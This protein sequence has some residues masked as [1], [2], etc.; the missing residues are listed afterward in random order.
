MPGVIVRY[1]SPLNAAPGQA[2]GVVSGAIGCYG[3]EMGKTGLDRSNDYFLPRH[4]RDELHSMETSEPD[5][6]LPLRHSVIVPSGFERGR[7]YVEGYLLREALKER[8]EPESPD[9]PEKKRQWLAAIVD[10]FVDVRAKAGG[11]RVAEER[12]VTER[13]QV[14]AL[15][16]TVSP[17]PRDVARLSTRGQSMIT[18]LQETIPQMWRAYEEEQKLEPGSVG[19]VWTLHLDKE[20][21]HAHCFLLPHAANGQRL[22]LS[23][24]LVSA[25]EPDGPRLRVLSDLRKHTLAIYERELEQMEKR[26]PVVSLAQEIREGIAARSLLA[27]SSKVATDPKVLR[28]AVVEKAQQF[29]PAGM[30]PSDL[31]QVLEGW[32]RRGVAHQ[33]A[34]AKAAPFQNEQDTKA[35]ESKWWRWMWLGLRVQKK[36]AQRVVSESVVRHVADGLWRGT[37]QATPLA[38]LRPTIEKTIRE[39]KPDV[40]GAL[41]GVA[42]DAPLRRLLKEV[43]RAIEDGRRIFIRSI[44]HDVMAA[45]AVVAEGLRLNFRSEELGVA[46]ITS[47]RVPDA[48]RPA[49]PAAPDN[50]PDRSSE[51]PP[52]R[53]EKPISLDPS[54]A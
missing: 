31:E 15:R 44:I 27:E 54:F 5:E 12:R 20:H 30:D 51:M 36:P 13:Q 24:G 14:V 28:K 47:A 50:P 41:K 35:I 29:T 45:K 26:R 49:M 8:I 53:S 34:G 22:A 40:L 10:L 17:D 23:N 1:T 3:D 19:Y 37:A 52:W 43:V 6:S 33:F 38:K 4:I 21:L 48:N 11:H 39:S 42:V 18:V 25:L 2:R 32:I 7:V 9:D 46:E 16:F